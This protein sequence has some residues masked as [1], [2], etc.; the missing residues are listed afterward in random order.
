MT[1]A[2][3]IL[4]DLTLSDVEFARIVALVR[5]EMGISLADAKRPLVCSR[6]AKRL[7]ALRLDTFSAYLD[8]LAQPD[9]RAEI[10]ELISAVT[11]NV[12]AFFRE[13]H[14]FETLM[15]DVLP[16]LVDRARAGGRVRIW[17]AGCSS[18]EE[19]W[20]IAACLNALCPDA[21]RLDI[22]ILGSDIDRAILARAERG[23]YGPDVPASVP[24]D[25]ARAMFAPRSGAVIADAL[26]RIVAF[27]HLNLNGAWPMRGQFDVIFC[28][29]VVI[30][31]DAP[32]QE[33]LWSRFG[34]QMPAGGW[35]MIGH[36]ERVAGQGAALFRPCGITTYRRFD[37][38]GER[39]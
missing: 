14:H 15:S 21:A 5:S 34:A 11:T 9:G 17:S 37:I 20:S 28:R 27:R 33:A 8:H 13:G 4:R 2:A 31:F 38:A 12:T 35:L 29:N 24:P 22:R 10:E 26:R 16:P 39:R 30:Y 6:L 23:E 7:R 18:G 25:L 36:S 1:A 3:H 19:V 32:T